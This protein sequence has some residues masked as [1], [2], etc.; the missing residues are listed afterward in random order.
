MTFNILSCCRFVPFAD[1][2]EK[3]KNLNKTKQSETLSEHYSPIPEMLLH[4]ESFLWGTKEE[5][6]CAVVVY[7]KHF[8]LHST[9]ADTPIMKTQRL[10]KLEEGGQERNLAAATMK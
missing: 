2:P 7:D 6:F 4:P 3:K 8:L 9:V 10:G 1:R 5:C